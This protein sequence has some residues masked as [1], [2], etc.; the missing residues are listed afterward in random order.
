MYSNY[1]INIQN[2]LASIRTI[3][4]LCLY[5]S[6]HTYL[7]NA[8]TS[9]CVRPKSALQTLA[10]KTSKK[11]R[12]RRER[13][14]GNLSKEIYRHRKCFGIV[15]RNEVQ[16]PHIESRMVCFHRNETLFKN[17]NIIITSKKHST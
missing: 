11:N 10:D 3:S 1:L 12:S 8:Y 14:R 15:V 17:N 4:I 6:T 2:L 16:N 9:R 5:T 13:E 7:S